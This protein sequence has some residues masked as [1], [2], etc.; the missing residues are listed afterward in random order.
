[1]RPIESRCLS[2]IKPSFV[3]RRVDQSHIGWLESDA[4]ALKPGD[5]VVA[6][7]KEIGQ[8]ARIERPDGRRAA[9]FPGDQLLLACGAR[10]A[11]DQFEAACPTSSGPA[12]LAAAGG[13]AGL[14]RARHG[15]M[16]PATAICIEGA[17]RTRDG[18]RMNLAHYRVTTAPGPSRLPVLAVCGSSMNAGK[19]H[20]VA[21]LVRGFARAGHQVAAIKV[22]GTGAGGDLWFYRDSGAHHVRDFTDAGLASTYQAPLD[23]ILIGTARLI[24]E[25]EAC[26]ADVVV[27]E[28]A[29]GLLQRETA[30]ILM[31]DS[32]R[33]RLTGI[34]F[35]ARDAMG[36]QAGLAWLQQAGLDPLAVSG[37]LT[38]APLAMREVT[39]VMRVPCLTPAA[40]ETAET[41][42]RLLRARLVSKA[43]SAA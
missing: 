33:A 20:T 22:T 13:I 12:H 4:D 21:A 31:S 6:R 5:L 14:V 1:M 37:C 41:V 7:V 26:G 2:K 40:L 43:P 8:H 10:Y 34:I 39:S 38:Q 35:A 19:T 23:E 30:E 17:L 11:P 36:A 16:K 28:L 29:D 32:F 18:R 9:L 3:T 27:L 24:A 42:S 25:A 15:Q